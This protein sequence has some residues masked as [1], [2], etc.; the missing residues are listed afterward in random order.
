MERETGRRCESAIDLAYLRDL[1]V[2]INHMVGVLRNQGVVVLD[3]PWDVD[4]DSPEARADAV[5]A[6]AARIHAIKPINQLLDD[7]RRTV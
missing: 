7:H 2:E 3:M 4:R 1:E 5:A 6:L